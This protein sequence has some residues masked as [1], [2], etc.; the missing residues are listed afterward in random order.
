MRE[1]KI[2]RSFL[3]KI[4]DYF[5][6]HLQKVILFGSMARQDFSPESDYDLLLIFDEIKEETKDFVEDLASEI[7]VEHGKLLSTLLLSQQQFEQMRFEPFI[8]NAQREGV[9]L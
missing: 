9:L 3:E 7:L 5:G 8:I 4:K 1:D 2:L 6:D